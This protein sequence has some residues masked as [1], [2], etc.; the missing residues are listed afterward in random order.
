MMIPLMNKIESP[1]K[2]KPANKPVSANMMNITIYRPP[3]SVIHVA[4]VKCLN[5]SIKCCII[6]T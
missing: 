4:S 3:W 6:I 1:G 5:N 2:K